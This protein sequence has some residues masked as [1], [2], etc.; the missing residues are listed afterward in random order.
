VAALWRSPWAVISPTP[1]A[2]HAPRSRRL[3][4]R[5]ENGAPEYPANTNGDP[6]KAI[7]PG[8]GQTADAGAA[9][10]RS[11]SGKIVWI[12]HC[13]TLIDRCEEF[14]VIIF[15]L[16]RRRCCI[17]SQHP[18]RWPVKALKAGKVQS[19][20]TLSRFITLARRAR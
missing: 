8:P 19:R 16:M 13:S 11:E 1:R 9:L 3:N 18:S 5:L 12:W 6:A 2:L 7:P 15:R 17:L 4:A 10:L 20:I 14:G